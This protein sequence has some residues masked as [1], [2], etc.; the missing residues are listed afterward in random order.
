MITDDKNR[1]AGFELE[2]SGEPK[3][4]CILLKL[5]AI[6]EKI[7]RDN[8]GVCLRYFIYL[9]YNIYFV[10][11]LYQPLDLMV[12]L[13]ELDLRTMQKDS[14]INKVSILHCQTKSLHFFI[15]KVIISNLYKCQ[16]H[17]W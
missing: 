17:K 7:N 5:I 4:N 12:G 2:V 15:R 11:Q 10:L 13:K 1:G 9:S 8:R 16:E 6:N 3:V 14:E